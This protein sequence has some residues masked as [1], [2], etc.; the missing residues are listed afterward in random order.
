MNA[1]LENA[2][3]IAGRRLDGMGVAATALRQGRDRIHVHAPAPQETPALKDLL[4]TPAGL[5]F[6]EV[7]TVEARQ[8][9]VPAGFK[10]YSVP[11]GDL[12]LREIPVVRGNDLVDAQAAFDQ[13]TNEPVIAFRFNTP[14][15]APLAGIR[16]RTSA[17]RSPSCSTTWFF[18]R[19]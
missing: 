4:T 3:V 15:H 18:R 2:L 10:S 1:A 9:R 8:G 17:G 16:P 5:G 6:H 11:P 12:L 7:S 14:A 19:R 13:R